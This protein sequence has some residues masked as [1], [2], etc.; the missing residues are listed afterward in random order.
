MVE[1]VLSRAKVSTR[2]TLKLKN[3]KPRFLLGDLR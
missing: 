1:G 3:P 2:E